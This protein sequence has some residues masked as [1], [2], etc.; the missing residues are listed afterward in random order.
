MCS[1]CSL[2]FFPVFFFSPRS[3]QQTFSDYA[4]LKRLQINEK[5]KKEAWVEQNSQKKK[6]SARN[7]RKK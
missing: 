6:K 4:G 2:F 1:D 5:K 7:M 3:K